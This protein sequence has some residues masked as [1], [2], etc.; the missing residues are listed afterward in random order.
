M[1]LVR[2]AKCVQSEI[3]SYNREMIIWYQS[4]LH[5]LLYYKIVQWMFTVSKRQTLERGIRYTFRLHNL[6]GRKS[7]FW[8]LV[9]NLNTIT[10]FYVGW[11]YQNLV[12]E[13]CNMTLLFFCFI[14]FSCFFFTWKKLR[15]ESTKGYIISWFLNLTLLSTRKP[16]SSV[17][18]R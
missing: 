12:E 16:I 15:F 17:V 13:R 9:S 6:Y 2:S 8:S 11:A 3:V 4:S 1:G 18:C 10:P 5:Y 7:C 14:V